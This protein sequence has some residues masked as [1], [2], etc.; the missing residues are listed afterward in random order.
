MKKII[1]FASALALSTGVSYAMEEEAMDKEMMMEAPAPSV[2]LAGSGKMGF[3]NVDDDDDSTDDFALIRAYK[4]AFSSS[5]VTDSGLMF[6]AGMSIRDDTGEEDMPVVKG[7]NVWVGAADGSWR[8]QFGGNDPGIEVV[9]GIGVADDNFGGGDADIALSGSFE[10]ATYRLSLAEPGGS[11]DWSLGVSYAISDINVGVGMDSENG[12]AIGVGT[13]LAGLSTSVYYS[14][15]ELAEADIDSGL[16]AFGGVTKRDAKP[17]VMNADQTITVD[18]DDVVVPGQSITINLPDVVVPAQNG[19]VI[20][21]P[22]NTVPGQ[23]ISGGSVDV[24]VPLGDPYEDY[25][26]WLPTQ[27]TGIM[28]WAA[29]DVVQAELSKT[30]EV[31]AKAAYDAIAGQ[32][33]MHEVTMYSVAQHVADLETILQRVT[34]SADGAEQTALIAKYQGY[35]DAVTDDADARSGFSGLSPDEMGMYEA[36]PGN[37][38][39]YKDKYEVTVPLPD[40][41]VTEQDIAAGSTTVDVPTQTIPGGSVDVT[42]TEKTIE[43]DSIE[44]VVPGNVVIEP[45][46]TARAAIPAANNVVAGTTEYTGFGGSVSVPAGEGTSFTIGYSSY[47]ADTR[48]EETSGMSF[49]DGE[50]MMAVDPYGG[51]SVKTSLIELGVSYE[52]GGGATLNASID[53]KSVESVMISTMA[54]ADGSGYARVGSVKETD[55]TTLEA[56]VSFSF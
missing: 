24:T 56:S 46:V 48:P 26:L 33:N 52:L 4:V 3:K 55:T 16:G 42:V 8:L 50:K 1:V 23:S 27:Y 5:S 51:G 41:S 44:V 53:K 29:L 40:V 19:I 9:P 38:A 30:S 15:S 13:E 2:A 14:K 12:F 36:D 11:G 43:Q 6:G 39:H 28:E 10:G 17:A 25:Q 18:L 47:K 31:T 22:E 37:I 7:S 35:F 54:K 21:I 32:T 45:A 20:A 49:Y 34:Y